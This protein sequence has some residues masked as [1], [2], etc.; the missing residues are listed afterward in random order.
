[1]KYIPQLAGFPQSIVPKTRRPR[2]YNREIRWAVAISKFSAANEHLRLLSSQWC[3]HLPIHRQDKKN[4]WKRHHTCPPSKST[5]FPTTSTSLP[6]WRCESGFRSSV[7][8]PWVPH[9]MLAV[10]PRRALTV[11]SKRTVCVIVLDGLEA[12]G[13]KAWRCEGRTRGVW[14]DIFDYFTFP[15]ANLTCSSLPFGCFAYWRMPQ[16]IRRH[17]NWYRL[18][19]GCGLNPQDLFNEFGINKLSLM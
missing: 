5:T 9:V 7:T 8:S 11:P 19:F 3:V 16:S 1:M 14:R 13:W 18:R 2:P 17:R 10:S 6:I 12:D 15:P 4:E